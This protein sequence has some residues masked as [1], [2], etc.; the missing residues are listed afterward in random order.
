MANP[1]TNGEFSGVSLEY[2]ARKINGTIP[3]EKTKFNVK[4]GA[5]ERQEAEVID[6][7]IV[8]FP[9]RTCQVMS[10]KKAERFGFL[11]MPEVMNLSQVEGK[12][13]PAGEYKNGIRD[14]DKV[15]GWI[16]M[17]ESLILA[18]VNASGHPLPSREN[19]DG[20]LVADMYSKE[21]LYLD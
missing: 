8:F 15:A 13:T 18:C 20:L 6:P 7:V 21:S 11:K 2:V 1:H 17:E 5:N 16:K 4:Q 3:T 14:K 19:A 10:M 9:N 12:S